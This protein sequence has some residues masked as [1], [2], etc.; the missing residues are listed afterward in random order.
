MFS[1]IVS[2]ALAGTAAAALLVTSDRAE[3]LAIQVIYDGVFQYQVD[4]NEA[5]AGETDNSAIVGHLQHGNVIGGFIL[6]TASALSSQAFGAVQFSA[7]GTTVH[8]TTA[9][10]ASGTHTLEI[11][12]SDQGFTAPGADA[13]WSLLNDFGISTFDDSFLVETYIDFGNVLFSTANL[14]HFG[15]QTTPNVE[16]PIIFAI[17]DNI[18]ETPF[19]I[20]HRILVQHTGT[21][22]SLI[23]NRTTVTPEPTALGLFGLAMLGI[24]AL[25]RRKAA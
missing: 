2:M 5:T 7:L 4:D 12:A 21:G 15:T 25:R 13:V 18:T 17:P 22:E 9:N 10:A 19:S 1:K 8:V 23:N 24:G 16:D 11:L 6:G 14:V 3:A 20:T